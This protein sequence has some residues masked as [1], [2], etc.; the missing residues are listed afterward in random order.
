MYTVSSTGN[1][2]LFVVGIDLHR[3]DDIA[4]RLGSLYFDFSSLYR[5]YTASLF[6]PDPFPKVQLFFFDH[7][8]CNQGMSLLQRCSSLTAREHALSRA[9]P[10]DRA[11]LRSIAQS[12]KDASWAFPFNRV[13]GKV[14]P[15]L[16]YNHNDE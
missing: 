9:G 13:Y 1:K 4:I 8:V 14:I 5:R 16:R 2:D 6:P 7:I 12:K 15:S 11:L 10:S 3:C